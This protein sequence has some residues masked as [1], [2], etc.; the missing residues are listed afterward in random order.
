RSFMASRLSLEPA[1]AQRV[2]AARAKDAEQPSAM[3]VAAASWRCV[4]FGGHGLVSVRA[5]PSKKGSG[6]QPPLLLRSGSGGGERAPHARDE[7][8]P[9]LGI[10][11][12]LGGSSAGGEHG[13]EGGAPRRAMRTRRDVGFH[14]RA[15][16]SR[17]LAFEVAREQLEDVGAGG[18]RRWLLEERSEALAQRSPGPV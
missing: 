9:K 5:G 11:L 1:R 15:G 12:R 8:G 17:D 18:A 4:G 14:R 3:R 10:Q 2:R 7:L 13:T 6:W 16:L